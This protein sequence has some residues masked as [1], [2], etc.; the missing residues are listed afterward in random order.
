M[1]D[2]KIH[3]YSQPCQHEPAFIVGTQEGLWAL[4]DAIDRALID[5][6]L[7][8]KKKH[9][10]VTNDG[11]SYHVVVFK[12]GP[13]VFGEM[14]L[15]YNLPGLSEQPGTDPWSLVPLKNGRRTI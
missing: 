7:C 12:V 5:D 11:E 14:R 15:P 1:T 3:I 8:D 10:A 13:T 9:E 4:R 6:L 2:P